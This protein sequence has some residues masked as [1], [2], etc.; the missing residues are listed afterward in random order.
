MQP[1]CPTSTMHL[2]NNVRCT[3]AQLITSPAT[4][5]KC[6]APNMQVDYYQHTKCTRFIVNPRKSFISKLSCKIYA[7]TIST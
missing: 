2:Q 7:S 5:P 3:I 4:A 6:W 1:T